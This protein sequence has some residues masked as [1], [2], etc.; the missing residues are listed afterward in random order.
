MP[1]SSPAACLFAIRDKTSFCALLTGLLKINSALTL[2]CFAGRDDR[3][4]FFFVILSLPGA[5]SGSHGGP[6][7]FA[8]SDAIFSEN[9]KGIVKNKRS[10]LKIHRRQDRR[11][12][13]RA[14]A[15]WSGSFHRPIP[16]ASLYKMYNKLSLCI[17]SPCPGRIPW[18]ATAVRPLRRG[19]FLENRKGIVKNKRSRLKKTPAARPPVL[20][21]CFRRFDP[22]LAARRISFIDGHYQSKILTRIVEM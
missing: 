10:R 15:G 21:P 9:R 17:Q 3:D 13:R 12:S 14:S 19:L 11:R 7:L 5:R 18:R 20:P 8:L 6:P 2:V 4:D 22:V 16:T 1:E